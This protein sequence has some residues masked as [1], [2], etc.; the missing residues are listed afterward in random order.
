M[1]LWEGLKMPLQ[2]KNDYMTL[3]RFGLIVWGLTWASLKLFFSSIILPLAVHQQTQ[4]FFG[5]H[6]IVY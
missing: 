2:N 4:Y 1:S 5:F 3:A 6:V